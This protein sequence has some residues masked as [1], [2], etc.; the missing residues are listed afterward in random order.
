MDA[1]A[2]LV[3]KTKTSQFAEGE[4][5]IQWYDVLPKISSKSAIPYENASESTA[6]T[7]MVDEVVGPWIW[8]IVLPAN[9]P[10]DFCP[11]YSTDLQTSSSAR[12][13]SRWY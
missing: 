4:V 10:I 11:I 12:I 2:I 6:T 1:G 5:P 13:T 9:E 7:V 8:S 3:G